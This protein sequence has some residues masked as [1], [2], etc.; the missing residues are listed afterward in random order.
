MFIKE[1]GK[2]RN[3][4][5]MSVHGRDTES[6]AEPEPPNSF[7]RL[8]LRKIRG[9]NMSTG[10]GKDTFWQKR[11]GRGKYENPNSEK[12]A[13]YDYSYSKGFP[14]SCILLFS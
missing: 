6:E 1:W 12:N 13:T 2:I 3:K 8:S 11:G 7:D 14:R 4:I 9:I 5:K 10:Q